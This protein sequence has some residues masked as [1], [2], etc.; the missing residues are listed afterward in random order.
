MDRLSRYDRK[1]IPI[2]GVG[3]GTPVK[4]SLPWLGDTARR[5]VKS[6]SPPPIVDGI[7]HGHEPVGF[8]TVLEVEQI[9]L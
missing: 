2:S 1:F 5:I 3:G 7:E 8:P 6:A 4:L 9:G